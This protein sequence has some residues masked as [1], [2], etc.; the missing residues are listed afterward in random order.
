M[1]AARAEGIPI[2]TAIAAQ[3]VSEQE[4]RRTFNCGVG[5]LLYVEA[6]RADE[7]AS[8][9]RDLGERGRLH[10]LNEV[11]VDGT[12]LIE[13]GEFVEMFATL[14]ASDELALGH[15]GAAHVIRREAQQRQL[16]RRPPRTPSAHPSRATHAPQSHGLAPR[17]TCGHR[18]TPQHRSQKQGQ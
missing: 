3:G 4:M 17:A 6:D 8:T 9:L 18:V 1:G 13:F 12:G 15:A 2:F 7:V 10:M 16:L 5:M 14:R 11:D